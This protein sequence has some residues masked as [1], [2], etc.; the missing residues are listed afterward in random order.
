M[1][2]VGITRF[3]IT[4][5][6]SGKGA[7]RF[8]DS[9][10]LWPAANSLYR[11]IFAALGMPLLPG[12]EVIDCTKTEFEAGYDYQLGIDVI[13]RHV[14]GGEST[15]QEKF[16][17]TDFNTVTVEH[18]QDW[19]TLEKGDFYKLKAN[20][21]FVGYDPTGCLQ[22]DPWVLLDWPCL[23]RVTAEY[24]IPWHLRGNYKDKARASFMF[25][26]IK[27]LPEEVC[28]D[29]SSRKREHRAPAAPPEATTTR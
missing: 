25:V 24:R 29:S 6:V 7:W 23:Q 4:D 16:L 15:L 19:V 3:N 26:K 21:Y 1:A 22:F 5:K 8:E 28:V 9:K 17:F 27:E 20:Y 18:C 14:V 10:K 2:N 11:E 12:E 13:L